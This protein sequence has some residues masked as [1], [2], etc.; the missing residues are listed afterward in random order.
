MKKQGGKQRLKTHNPYRYQSQTVTHYW[1]KKV[2]YY[3]EARTKRMEV[4][5]EQAMSINQDMLNE[6]EICKSE[7][8]PNEAWENVFHKYQ[9]A[10]NTNTGEFIAEYLV[11]NNIAQRGKPLHCSTAIKKMNKSYKKDT[12]RFNMYFYQRYII[13]CKITDLSFPE[14]SEKNLAY[15]L[16]HKY[17]VL[18]LNGSAYDLCQ[19]RVEK[20]SAYGD[21]YKKELQHYQ[22][23]LKKFYVADTKT[24]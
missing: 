6:W 14:T 4:L 16:H 9:P 15:F 20:Y 3:K 7:K 13:D 21:F 11:A 22:N 5:T 12:R 17:G 19:K 1:G 18:L 8:R 24:R 10:F 2:E 23:L